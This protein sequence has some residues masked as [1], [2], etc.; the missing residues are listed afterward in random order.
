MSCRQRIGKQSNKVN[1]Q[2]QNSKS[3][4]GSLHS[5]FYDNCVLLNVK[6]NAYHHD[7]SACCKGELLGSRH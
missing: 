6:N 2:Q 4:H 3:Y 1:E 7:N 5:Q